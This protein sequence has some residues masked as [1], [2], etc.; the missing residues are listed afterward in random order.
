MKDVLLLD[1]VKVPMSCD[2]STA[3]LGVK[4]CHKIIM[5]EGRAVC[6]QKTLPPGIKL[7]FGYQL[8]P[9]PVG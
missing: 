6:R 9:C 4:I 8:G 2:H 5:V 3:A 1:S 7:P